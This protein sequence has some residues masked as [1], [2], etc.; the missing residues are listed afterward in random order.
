[1]PISVSQ[2]LNTLSLPLEGG[3]ASSCNFCADRLCAA[4]NG[5]AGVVTAQIQSATS[6]LRV[7]YDPSH[8][9]PQVVTDEARRT[10]TQLAD[11][12]THRTY[13]VSGMDCAHCAE[14]LE[15]MARTLPGVAGATVHF[16]AARLQV[17]FD[18]RQGR[19]LAE[20]EQRAANMGFPLT[21][22]GERNSQ[23]EAPNTTPWL[24]SP[25]GGATL[26]LGF[27]VAGLLSEYAFHAPELAQRT[28]FGA[29]MVLG[30]YRFARAGLV[31]LSS[32]T[33]NTNLLMAI[34]AV[35]AV[36]IG[37]WGEAAMTVALYAIGLALEGAAMD[38]TRRSLRALM[39]AYPNE[40]VRQMPDGT[41]QTVPV[42]ELA[43][44]DLVRVVPG[45]RI[46]ADG[47]I[48]AGAS[49]V[50]EAAITG[51]SIP[52][53]RTTGDH[54]FAG[55]I[56]GPGALIIRVDVPPSESALSRMLALVEEAQ[57]RKAPL[58]T[59]V[60]RFGRVYTPTVLVVAIALAVLGPLLQPGVN[61]IYRALTLLVVSCP[62]ALIIATPV[63]YVSALAR[64]ARGGA[65]VKGGV[66][67]EAMATA[68]Q[69]FIDKTGTLT[70]GAL[71]VTRILTEADGPESEGEVLRQ[72][73]A[74]EQYSEHPIARA[75][76]A[77]AEA[78]GVVVPPAEG[79]T[80]VPGRGIQGRV[81]GEMIHVGNRA[82]LN[83][84]K[85]PLPDVW[86]DRDGELAA[87]GNTTLLVAVGGTVR[88]ILAVADTI[89]PEAAA[90][91]A[92]LQHSG[93][94]VVMLTG[95]NAAVGKA[96][97]SAVG[98]TDVRAGLLPEDKL[99]AVRTAT[100]QGETVFVG[101]GLNDAPALAAATV[102]IGMGTGTAAALEA[103]DIGLLQSDLGRL[104][105]LVQLSEAT[106]DIVR[107]NI[108]IS[109]GAVV[110]LLLATLMGNLSLPLGVIGH[111]GSALLVIANGVR[112]LTPRLLPLKQ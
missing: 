66:Y 67:L 107:V 92:A 99:N 26:S 1:M 106:R 13:Q 93:R 41:C 3:A 16:T 47:S 71:R 70:L 95:D 36:V 8:I 17:E 105:E 29:S 104:H 22:S 4:V 110:L 58:Q 109:I 102:G 55:S 74:L 42:S 73:A 62:C 46:P 24:L 65:L 88:A 9:S 100:E 97:G 82:F 19:G 49:A 54:V 85:I 10:Q 7:E 2:Q 86:A 75:I 37:H 98:I 101:D 32:R 69:V 45:E 34:A 60:E 59:V 5:L 84:E 15:Q 18:A 27:L 83:T 39:D 79:V 51:E 91:V 64:A 76:V 78:R 103:A 12:Y 40:A 61:W 14:S 90:V 80:A 23:S 33:L 112:L 21:E 72:V 53:D 50:N 81:A 108:A 31:A 111:E 35:G 56:N 20:I 77:E 6:T 52:A 25:A 96:V 30:G 87:S 11:L 89:R 48:M 43:V 94:S 28:L 57:G 63:A 38:R 44:G 68:K